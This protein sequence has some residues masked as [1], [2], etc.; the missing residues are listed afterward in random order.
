M[1]VKLTIAVTCFDD[2]ERFWANNA[3]TIR[4]ISARNDV[5]LIIVNT[6]GPAS[7]L[8]DN[9]K[10]LSSDYWHISLL[11]TTT[12]TRQGIG[13]NLALQHSKGEYIWFIDSDDSFRLP[14][15]DQLLSFKT[16]VVSINYKM[17]KSDLSFHEK[18]NGSNGLSADGIVFLLS[19]NRVS[20][21]CWPYIY[22]S[23]I[24]KDEIQFGDYYFEDL[25]F[26]AKVFSL[27]SVSYSHLSSSLYTYFYHA[28][29]TSRGKQ[30][31]KLVHR[32]VAVREVIVAI[33]FGKKMGLPRKT[34]LMTLYLL[35]HGFWLTLKQ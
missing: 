9:L 10:K 3:A 28:N 29:S 15:Q 19:T 4:E 18:V 7:V 35:Y 6:F 25:V 14:D 24:I 33:M 11:N 26:N 27:N 17:Q 22:R 16:D 1:P 8:N 2:S 30:Y 31:R 34:A 5:E 12:K 21:A 13:R 23:S 20:N 32:W